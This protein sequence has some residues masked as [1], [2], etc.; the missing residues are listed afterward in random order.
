MIPVAR[1]GGVNISCPVDGRYSFYNSPYPAHRLSTG[2][3]IYF[4]KEFNEVATSPVEGIVELVRK[5]RSPRGK[6]FRDSGYDVVTLLRSLE[7]PERVI[8]LLHVEPFVECGD[9]VVVGQE[10][11]GLI[12]SGYFGF[13]TSP[14]IHLEIRDPI[15]PLRARG[16][17]PVERLIDVAE[18][19]FV[20]ELKGLV[21][22]SVPEFSII[23]LGGISSYGLPAN[24]GGI[25]GL[26]D[27]GIPY[28]GWLGAHFNDVPLMGNTITLLEKPI[29]VIK[30]FLK[31]TC[32]AECLK[33]DIKVNGIPIRGMSLH[34]S[35]REEFEVKLI[36]L[37]LGRLKLEEEVE[38][39]LTID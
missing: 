14:H 30:N 29:A 28:Y 23:K 31:R 32:V 2:I 11:G 16:G 27:G 39:S 6:S 24:V 36:P 20:E 17:H 25:P 3:D 5:I 1:A 9:T 22:K 26:L 8:K 37:G 18:T 13:G 15:D 10:L 33:F 38:V 19:T 21:T 35:P 4:D 7:N 34:L 12:R